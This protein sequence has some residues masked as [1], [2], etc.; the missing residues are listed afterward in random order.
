MKKLAAL[1]SVGL[2]A[3][4]LSGCSEQASAL[5]ASGQVAAEAV[6]VTGVIETV[7]SPDPETAQTALNDISDIAEK[8]RGIEGPAD[9]T[10]LRDSWTSSID[11]FVAAGESALAGDPGSLDAA[12]AQMRTDTEA[13]LTYC[14]P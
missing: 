9:F 2:A 10:E 7:S 11:A 12:A 14:T 3:L 4:L 5:A 8:I 13:V 6:Q 1:A